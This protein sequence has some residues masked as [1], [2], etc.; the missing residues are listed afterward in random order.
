MYRQWAQ[1]K[2]DFPDVLLLFRMGDFYEMFGED[3]E[4]GAQVLGLTLTARKYSGDRK[5]P[6]CG[7]PY[8]ALDRYLRVLVEK[9][10]R[11]AICDQ[12]EDPRQAKGLVRREV[13]RVVTP[14]TLLEEGLLPES[15]HN[16]LASVA[17][18]GEALGLAAVDI[19]TGDFLVTQIT[20]PPEPPADTLPGLDNRP[21]PAL[22]ALSDELNRLRPAEVLVPADAAELQVHLRQTV[23]APQTPISGEAAAFETPAGELCTFFGVESLRGFGCHDLPAAIAAAANA[24]RYLQA[25]QLQALPRLTGLTT[26]HTAQFMV[27]DATTRRNL[28]LTE[29]LRGGKQATLVA[30]LDKTRTPMGARLLRSY[31]LQPLINLPEIEARLEAVGNLV[32]NGL[33]LEGLGERLKAIYDLERLTSRVTARTAN[34]RDL[35]ALGLSLQRLPEVRAELAPAEAALLATLRDQVDELADLS[36]LLERALTEEPPIGL[37]EGGL[38]RPGYAPELDELRD[39][40]AHG[41]EW[42]AA[43]QDR[44]RARTG[45]KNLKIGYNQ[46]F[47]YYLEVTRSFAHLVPEDYTRK[48]TL[49]NAERFVTPQLKEWEAKVLGADE[50]SQALEYELFVALREQVATEAE[51]ITFTARAL[52]QLDVLA[53]L[54][55]AAVEYGYTRPEITDDDA[56]TI[57]AGRHPVVERTLV[58]EAFVPNDTRLDCSENRFMI[59]TGPNMAGKSTYLRQVALIAL[60][61]QMGSFVPARQARLGLVDRIFTRVGAS[62]DLAT[63]QSTFMVEMTETANILHNATARSLVILDEIGRGTSTFDGLSLAWAVAEYLVQ[64]I[65]AKSLFATHYHHLNEL[66]E[67]LPGVRNL[68]VLVK[69]EGDHITFLRQIVPGGTDRSYG[70]QVAHLAGLPREVIARAR[71]V[72]QTIEREDLAV[73]PSLETARK[74]APTVQLQLFEAAPHPILERLKSLNPDTLTPLEALVVLGEL[75]RELQ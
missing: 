62:D 21:D 44:E 18:V 69:E 65:G 15:E 57:I 23:A 75:R 9:G 42:I 67:I 1:A 52:A 49:T 54:A 4:L 28:E 48:Q 26:Y 39:A 6:M 46:V 29:S 41:R 10:H 8:H 56:L 11:A 30:L 25:T 24:L 74:I 70:I 19:S 17:Q 27:I 55:R 32:S 47:G 35:R 20:P 66:A 51:R 22:T 63:G 31:I 13:T 71:E 73:M 60:M 38:I 33:L 43:L 59:I 61:A 36:D 68:R 2:R 12:V 64:Q 45:I 16:Y 53:A 58:D 7:I 40:A 50:R 3:A 72:L 5:M 14:G 37:T 34:G